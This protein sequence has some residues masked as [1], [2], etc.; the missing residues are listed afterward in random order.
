[1][2]YPEYGYIVYSLSVSVVIVMVSSSL[3]RRLARGYGRMGRR[4][5]LVAQAAVGV[6]AAMILFAILLQRVGAVGALT[7]VLLLALP[8]A[9]ALAILRLKRHRKPRAVWDNPVAWRERITRTATSR[10]AV[11]QLLY[12]VLS[13]LAV[14]VVLAMK[15]AGAPAEDARW[16]VFVVTTIQMFVVLMIGATMAAS[17]VSYERE[18]GTLDVLLTTPITPRYFITGKLLGV[19]RYLGL[20]LGMILLVTVGAYL[21]ASLPVEHFLRGLVPGDWA[22]SLSGGNVDY[23]EIRWDNWPAVSTA[24]PLVISGALAAAMVSLG[25]TFSLRARS[26]ATAAVQAALTVFAAAAVTTGCCWISGGIWYAGPMA[27]FMS[28]F[29]ANYASLMPDGF[30]TGFGFSESKPMS[31]FF[32][33]V[34][35]HAGVLLAAAT[36]GTFALLRFRGMVRTFDFQTRQKV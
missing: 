35:M 30:M 31:D 34:G 24:Y 20:F 21:I 18:Q 36:Y 25:M 33:H 27:A 23:P 7:G 28:P 17:T 19:I 32:V 3:V 15:V 2:Q 14:Y 26:T 1:V 4:V 12:V 9:T 29:L 11:V 22:K 5:G 13:I 10:R 8:V 16:F 6:I